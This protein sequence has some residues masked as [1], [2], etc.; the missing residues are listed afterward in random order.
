[1]SNFVKQY[2]QE[3]IQ[4]LQALDINSIEQVIIELAKIRDNNGRL[5]IL[6]C[7]GSAG[8]ASHSCNDFRKITKL[9]SYTPT[10][11]VSE[12]TA[13]INDDGWSS[14]FAAWLEGS[15]LNARDA[16]LVLSV[17]GGNEEKGISTNLIEAIRYA[18]KMNTT[19]LGIVGRD[20]GYTKQNADACITIPPLFPE[21]ITPNTEGLCSVILHC[22]VSHPKLQLATT[23]WESVK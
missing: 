5:F 4:I 2:L 21:H 10:D 6:G 11:N 3:N 20:G 15:H 1:M 17:G 8:S 12:L 13:R 14:C 23:K 9:E 7:G 19:I 22:L 18:K 16:I